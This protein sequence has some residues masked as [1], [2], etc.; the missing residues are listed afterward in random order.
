MSEQTGPSARQVH[1]VLAAVLSQPTLL[2][3][4]RSSPS[5]QCLQCGAAADFDVS[6]IWRFSGLATKVRH[7]DLRPSLPLTF[8][9]LDSAGLS[10]EFFASYALRAADLRK[11][12]RISKPARIASLAEFLYM[13]LD[14][15]HAIHS[16]LW[17]LVR[18]ESSIADLRTLATA[19]TAIAPNGSK[20]AFSVKSALVRSA[21][22]V[23]HEM[24]R[25]PAS[26][27]KTLKEGGDLA[28]LPPEPGV[29]AYCLAPDGIRTSVMVIDELAAFLMD[30]SDGVR[31]VLDMAEWLQDS[32]VPL[33]VGDLLVPIAD[34]IGRGLLQPVEISLCA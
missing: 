9:L 6:K 16:I 17:D 1:A 7:N 29:F 22:A 13:W 27:I 23:R 2:D 24:G 18:H 20:T 31:S 5:T 8:A 25:N 30:A 21:G 28:S 15:T 26:I 4:W 11:Q 14:H 3:L 34:L 10:I 12:G 32:G 33:E 19:R